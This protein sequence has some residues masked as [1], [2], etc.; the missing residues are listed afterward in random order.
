MSIYYKSERKVIYMHF[1]QND[2]KQILNN[3]TSNS[4]Q[5]IKAVGYCRFSSDNQR[6]ESIEAQQKIIIE[7]AEKNNYEIIGWYLDRA[8]SGT[9]ANRPEFQRMLED[10]SDKSCPFSAVLVHK[11]DRFSRNAADA[12]KYKDVLQDFGVELISTVEKIVNSA[13]GRRLYGIMSN[14]NEYYSA[15]L[16]LEVMKGLK[17]NAAKCLWNGGIPPLG[18]DVKEQ[19]LVINEAEAII[20]KEI[21]EMAAKGLGYHTIVKKLNEKGFKTKKGKEFG[22]NSIYDLIRNERYMGV[23]TFNKR[24]RKSLNGKR[25]NHKQKNDNE[26]IR[27]PNG[28]PQ[29]VSEELWQR[30][31]L[32]RQISSKISTNSKHEYL[33]SGL[34]TCGNCGSKMHGNYR[35]KDGRTSYGTYRCNR[36]ENKLLCDCREIRSK[37]LEDFVVDKLIKHF[38]N[39]SIIDVMTKQINSKIA[40]L[41]KIDDD[42]IRQVKNSLEG[43]QTAR[44]NL[45]D[46]LATVGYNKLLVDKLNALE[47]QI[48]EYEKM[49]ETEKEQKIKI[50]VTREDVKQK[51]RELNDVIKSPTNI[52]STKIMLRQYIDRIEVTNSS[53]EVTFKVAFSFL[54]GEVEYKVCYNHTEKEHRFLIENRQSVCRTTPQKHRNIE[55]FDS[56][57]SVGS[58]TATKRTPNPYR[59]ESSMVEIRGVEPLTFCMRSRRA[60]NCAIPPN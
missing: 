53:V 39:E 22:K 54:L 1:N 40:E 19:K 38:F 20:V 37:Y 46:T 12:I 23:Y 36:K 28:C 47:K 41:M 14:I 51:I 24:A 33:L 45:V 4:Q 59:I 48:F 56:F 58:G 21:F 10:V 9:N 43:L 50:K 25:N 30:A 31:N 18:Y 60:T 16:G 11:T 13:N 32:S 44:A 57:G 49:V 6:D 2:I 17:V 7:Y 15:N 52:D 26:V 42:K 55:N 8:F 34:V 29:I 3:M 27:I 5:K 35:A